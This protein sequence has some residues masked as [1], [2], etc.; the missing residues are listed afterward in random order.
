ILEDTVYV[1]GLYNTITAA[2]PDGTIK[3]QFRENPAGQGV[4][5][6]P[7]VGP[8]GNIYVVTDLG[9]LGAF[10]LS[11]QGQL[12]WN[13]PGFESYGGLGG[14]IM[15]GP[16]GQ[17]YFA[18]SPLW[19][20][21]LLWGI[22]LDGQ[23]RFS[24]D[25]HL[26]GSGPAVGP[27]GTVYIGWSSASQSHHLEA[28]YPNGVLKWALYGLN[29]NN[30]LSTPDV[31]PDGIV[32]LVGNLSFLH[33]VNP[34]GSIRWEYFENSS[35]GS[36]IVSP[37]NDLVLMGGAENTGYPYP[38]FIKAVSTDGRLLWTVDLPYENGV[39]IS[40]LAWPRFTPDGRPAY[41]GTTGNNYAEDIYCYLYAIDTSIPRVPA[42][43]HRR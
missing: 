33:A 6:G 11:P 13:I 1:A 14:E 19:T 26:G 21:S 41:V 25:I 35:L 16:P 29:M 17:F 40:T 39:Y 5:A 2:N 37:R 7:N 22:R 31:G 10:A 38:T 15:F 30:H 42:T 24:Y 18:E 23:I 28:L 27:D 43:P 8:D 3:W 32:Y 12:L 34:D 20:T 4:M 36:P 9:G